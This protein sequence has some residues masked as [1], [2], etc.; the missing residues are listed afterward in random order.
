MG[1]TERHPL[2]TCCL[3]NSLF[4]ELFLALSQFT[5]AVFFLH[6]AHGGF[7]RSSITA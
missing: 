7:A 1:I 3:R 4:A 6:L 5:F 2:H